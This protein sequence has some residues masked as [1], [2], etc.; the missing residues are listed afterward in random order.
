[1]ASDAELNNSDSIGFHVSLGF[2]EVNRI[3]CFTKSL[4]SKGRIR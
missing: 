3:V 2:R 1:M 4:F